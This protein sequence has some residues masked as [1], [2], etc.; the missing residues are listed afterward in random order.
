[1]NISSHLL[2]FRVYMIC[3]QDFIIN[4]CFKFSSFSVH[5]DIWDDMKTRPHF[6]TFL[7]SKNINNEPQKNFLRFAHTNI[8]GLEEGLS[9]HDFFQEDSYQRRRTVFLHQQYVEV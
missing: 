4:Y 2:L 7:T 9:V 3:V 5:Q 6:S 8:P 1:M